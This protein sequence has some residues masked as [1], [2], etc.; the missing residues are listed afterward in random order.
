MLKKQNRLS[1]VTNKSKGTFYSSPFFNIKIHDGQEKTT[2]FAFVVSKK[3]SRKAVVRNR[4][5]RVL[6]A[7]AGALIQKMKSD[8]DIIIFS[9]KELNSKQEEE[10]QESMTEIFS[11]AKIIQQ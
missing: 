2:R 8:K 5:K 10:V 11:K 7:A 6:R 4:T 3:I 1:R 9:K